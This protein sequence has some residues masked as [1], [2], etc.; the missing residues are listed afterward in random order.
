MA[1]IMAL[2]KTSSDYMAN[3]NIIRPSGHELSFGSSLARVGQLGAE[4]NCYLSHY[5]IA[6]HYYNN[7]SY[8]I[9]ISYH[10]I[11]LSYQV[12]AATK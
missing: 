8:Y 5:H 11:A 6:S 4:N 1:P 9:I 2:K 10:H 12:Q 3:K 7:I